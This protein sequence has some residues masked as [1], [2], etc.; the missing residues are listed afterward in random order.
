MRTI[1]SICVH[2]ELDAIFEIVE[3]INRW[4]SIFPHYSKVNTVGV[5]ESGYTVVDMV[6]KGMDAGRRITCGQIVA[7]EERRITYEYRLGRLNG[8]REEWSFEPFE[9][10]VHVTVVHD[11]PGRSSILRLLRMRRGSDEH[12]VRSWTDI[13]LRCLKMVAER[14]SIAKAA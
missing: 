11:V 10:G 9:G 7:R 4:P 8:I 14:E 6:V 2:A 13:T 1:N 5:D 3:D 12:G